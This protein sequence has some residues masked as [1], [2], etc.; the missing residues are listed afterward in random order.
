[1]QASVIFSL[2]ASLLTILWGGWSNV[3]Y[4]AEYLPVS[5]EELNIPLACESTEDLSLERT[6]AIFPAE[7]YFGDSLYLLHY[8]F[9]KSDST[10]KGL[11]DLPYSLRVGFN[12][13][14]ITSE[15][16]EYSYEYVFEKQ[17][18]FLDDAIYAYKP[19]RFLPGE[20]KSGF[21]TIIDLP[22][23]EDWD[24]P[25]W[26]DI[27][28]KMT[29]EGIACSLSFRISVGRFALE[30][31][32]KNV[33]SSPA[34]RKLTTT[35]NVKAS[36]V[37]KPRPNDELSLLEKWYNNTPKELFPVRKGSYKVPSSGSVIPDNKESHIKVGDKDFSPW[38]LIRVGNRKPSNP[39]NPTT[40]EGWQKLEAQLS[41]STMRDEIRLTR[42]QLEYYSADSEERSEYWKNELVNWLSTLP[43]SQRTAYV[44]MI[45]R[46]GV[47]Q[48]IPEY[49]SKSKAL[50]IALEPLMGDGTKYLFKK[51]EKLYRKP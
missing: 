31:A 49:S 44:G 51:V 47:G 39:N 18:S 5:G 9:N 17:N 30:D 22:P 37:I 36:F 2:F 23:L 28:E 8:D 20:R 43:E 7:V 42:L 48:T 10:L 15:L 41:P 46:Q 24:D 27:R 45:W 38:R 50:T 6:L 33:E 21:Y 19:D 16:S 25:F 40:L 11:M 14:Q 34:E 35:E 1:M 13:V 3:G 32:P 26:K 29:P 12:G 4:A